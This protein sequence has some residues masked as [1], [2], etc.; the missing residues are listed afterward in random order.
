M[1]LFY[2]HRD[3][4]GGRGIVML[5]VKRAVL[6][7][8]GKKVEFKS[9]AENLNFS[10]SSIPKQ[11]DTKPLT[12]GCLAGWETRQPNSFHQTHR[13]FQSGIVWLLIPIA[14]DVCPRV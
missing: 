6:W 10:P 4:I 9:V 13:I 11:A 14:S 7:G 2:Q 3:G 5:N 8:F 1:N 12:R